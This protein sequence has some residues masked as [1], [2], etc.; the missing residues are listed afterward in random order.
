MKLPG[1]L[2]EGILRRRYK[3]FLADVELEDG[4][5]ITAHTPNTGSMKECAVPG[6]RVLLS[7]SENP[8]RKLAYT[9]ELIRVNGHW[10]DTHTHRTNRIVEEG[11]RQG[12]IPGFSGYEIRPEF[13]IG[14]SRI[15]F[16]LTRG[17]E[18]ILIEV[19]NVTLTDGAGIACFPDAVTLRGRKHLL[20]L[21]R[22]REGGCRALMFFLVQR[23]EA[24]AFR[25][26]EEIDPEY[27][28]ALSRVAAGGVEILAC[29]SIVTP[30]ENL[31]GEQLPV[32]L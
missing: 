13:P 32:L 1:P 23:G 17:A 16:L 9:L 27:A 3:R 15:D 2:I 6:Y 29:R 24:T 5:L 19:K 14:G 8:L 22:A 30:E 12:R 28:K 18:R 11:L 25:P 10:V 7:R 31:V 20:E 26:A 21:L 4:R